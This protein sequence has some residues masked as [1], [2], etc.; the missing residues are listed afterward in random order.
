MALEDITVLILSRGRDDILTRSLEYWASLPLTVLVLHHTNSPL[1]S[2]TNCENVKYINSNTPYGERCAL[3]AQYISSKYAILVSDDD[4]YLSSGLLA[5]SEVLEARNDLVSVGGQTISVGKYGKL[6]TGTSAYVHTRN[7]KN[8]EDSIFDRLVKHFNVE[9]GYING[10]MYRL[11]RADQFIDLMKNL[12]SLT[13][14]RTPY[15][16]EVSSEIFANAAGKSEYL[17]QVLWIRNWINPPVNHSEWK[18]N[19]YFFEWA[20]NREFSDEFSMWRE[21][22][23]RYLNLDQESFDDL[24]LRII[25]V[26]QISEQN[27]ISKLRKH[28]FHIPEVMKYYLRR[29][30]KPDSL[31][32]T[33][34]EEI[35]N[36][37]DADV[38]VNQEE[39][40]R[41]LK[42]L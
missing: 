27:E 32:N 24:L 11:F 34:E 35:Q 40:Q 36:L 15:I 18:R 13:S 31:P 26:R 20:V 21:F 17:N 29:I 7:Y 37:I 23:E 25:K 5:L 14:I 30:F 12:G 6:V 2:F 33:V 3:A 38:L 4:F 1:T 41:V 16:F 22:I 19:L 28:S 9:V 42:F 39:V 8:L 10:S